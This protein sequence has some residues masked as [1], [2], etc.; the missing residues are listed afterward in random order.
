MR[1]PELL[2]GEDDGPP[3][4]ELPPGLTSAQRDAITAD[5]PVLCVIAGAGAGK[6]RV[7]TLR[8]ARRIR[9][10]SMDP[11]RVVVCTFSRKAASELRAR[12]FHLGVVHGINAGTFHR[13]ALSLIRQRR[14]DERLAPL[15]VL[16]DRRR[17]LDSLDKRST[18]A[19]SRES[20]KGSRS[21]GSYSSSRPQDGS[22]RSSRS[23]SLSQIDTE[24]GW[25]KSR[26]IPPDRYPSEAEYHMRRTSMSKAAIAEVYQRYE[27][28]RKRKGL[29]DLDD[30]LWT[31]VEML[32]QDPQFAQGVR[33]RFRHL[34]VDEMQDVNPVQFRLLLSILNDDPDLFVVGDPNQ[35]VYQWNGSDPRLLETFPETVNGARVIRLDENHRSSPQIVS[36]ANAVIGVR[37]DRAGFSSRTDG[38]APELH[39]F[40]TDGEE[41]AWVAR[42]VWLS[43]S[44]GTRWS[45]QAI[46]ART[47]AQLTLLTEALAKEHV[48]FNVAGSDLG[49]A[50]DLTRPADTGEETADTNHDMGNDYDDAVTVATFHRAKGLQWPTV[51]VIGLSESLVPI[52]QARTPEAIDEERRLLYVALT[53]AELNLYCSWATYRDTQVK[54]VKHERAPSRWLKEIEETLSTLETAVRL[55][56]PDAVSKNVAALK[57]M[58]DS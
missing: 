57:A 16:S 47:N 2:A 20:T 3:A 15:T 34:F 21:A 51:F 38:P 22:P 49:P 9:E 28:E 50:S 24:I 18:S 17:V 44:P 56:D 46:L 53:R 19:D 13:I 8:V 4:F 54:D 1:Y 25:A 6:T 27:D 42:K 48:P 7:L 30:L 43:H 32:D 10:G 55:S 14:I 41:A 11:D 37:D 39:G 58:L 12:L 26:M 23:R 33:W 45:H 40:V 29:L 52:S 31:C 35:S 36:V 5:D